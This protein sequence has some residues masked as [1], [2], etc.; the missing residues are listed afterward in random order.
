MNVYR[1]ATSRRV[2][3]L[4]ALADRRFQSAQLALGGHNK[5]NRDGSSIILANVC[6]LVLYGTPRI[7]ES[8]EEA[9]KRSLQTLLHK[10]PNF[11]R[12]GRA[13]PFN[14][15]AAAV[16]A[17]DFRKYVLPRLPGA[18]DNDKIYQVLAQ[19]PK[20]LLWHTYADKSCAA[21]GVKVPNVS[22][23]LG[24]SRHCWCLGILPPG[25]FE[26]RARSDERE[27]EKA[28]RSERK[29]RRPI[30][31]Q[32]QFW[33]ELRVD[34]KRKLLTAEFQA[35]LSEGFENGTISPQLFGTLPPPPPM[36]TLEELKLHPRALDPFD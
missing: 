34:F 8:L 18:A 1:G 24:F 21:C 20:W 15:S 12:N 33:R 26:L 29:A 32:H 6:L 3:R 19:A 25:P 31:T 28:N 11:A 30:T 2:A 22:G 27:Y 10:F 23:M 7:D 13:N 14:F 36:F 9:W 5:I 35:K 4:E 17:D 16:V